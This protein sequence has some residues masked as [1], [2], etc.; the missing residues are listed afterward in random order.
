MSVLG[1]RKVWL[2]IHL[3]LGLFAGA[4]LMVLGLTGSVLVFSDEIDRALNPQLA[5]RSGVADVA[6][7]DEVVK[8][9][10]ARTGR[11]PHMLELPRDS[12][13]HYLAFVA[14]DGGGAPRALLVGGAEGEVLADR[15]F[16]SYF[17][18]FCRRLH[19]DLLLDD[20]IG[21]IVV[22]LLGVLGLVSVATG[23]YLWWPRGSAGLLRALAFRLQ[24]NPRAINYELHRV[25]GFYLL[26]VLLVVTASGVYLALP[27]P[28][29]A[30]VGSFA[31]VTPYPEH[32]ATAVPAEGA[33]AL[34]LADVAQVVVNRTPGALITGFSVPTRPEDAYAVFY[35]APDEPMSDFGR[36]AVWI[37][38]YTGDVLHAHEYT[39]GSVA[40][41]VF[42]L[43]ILLHN[44]EVAGEFGAWL[45]FLAGVVM[46]LLYV[47]GF[48]LWW[49]RRRPQ[50]RA[51]APRGAL[52]SRG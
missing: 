51:A 48:Y 8:A 12:Q 31:D 47:T 29:A 14:E 38:P 18:S 6:T 26:I 35:R 21:T 46:P 42:A 3:Y 15:R 52:V 45:V 28:F 2:K 7:P 1:A 36:S 22:A 39:Q 40:D 11:R 32:L 49:V 4:L 50:R 5:V 19:T 9:V 13:P 24:R 16:G 10:E 41:R 34:A 37:D 25:S 20:E 44:G 30:A 17:V 27:G 23:L 43:Q 33:R